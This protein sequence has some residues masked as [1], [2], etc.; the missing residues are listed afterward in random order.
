MNYINND[1]ARI[2]WAAILGIVVGGSTVMIQ[3]RDRGFTKEDLAA[4]YQQGQTDALKVSPPSDRLEAVCAALW[5]YT[6][7]ET[8]K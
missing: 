6:N 2:C 1:I 4:A 3:Y 7:T 5:F 8:R